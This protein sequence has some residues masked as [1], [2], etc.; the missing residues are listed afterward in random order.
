M[1]AEDSEEDSESD[2]PLVM[3]SWSLVALN[4]TDIEIAFDFPDPLQVS[5]NAVPDILLV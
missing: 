5:A 4:S 1:K 2:S 3:D